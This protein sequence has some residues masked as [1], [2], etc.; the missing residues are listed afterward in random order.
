MQVLNKPLLNKRMNEENPTW[1]EPQCQEGDGVFTSF[2][3]PPK[4]FRNLRFSAHRIKQPLPQVLAPIC[5]GKRVG[6]RT[7][8]LSW[9][10]ETLGRGVASSH[11]SLR[12]PKSLA[13]VE[14]N[15]GGSLVGCPFLLS[16]ASFLGSV[17]GGMLG[18]WP[19]GHP[20]TLEQGQGT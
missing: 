4:L 2:Q 20:S 9:Q 15:L 6:R 17:Q 10:A 8:V 3:P 11:C 19:P 1:P 7:C 12:P 13:W 16:K 18:R 5:L 14:G